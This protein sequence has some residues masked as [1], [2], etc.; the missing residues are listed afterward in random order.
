MNAKILEGISQEITGKT[1]G[2]YESYSKYP[3]TTLA[4]VLTFIEPSIGYFY[5]YNS[6]IGRMAPKLKWFFSFGNLLLFSLP[7][8]S[9]LFS[10]NPKLRKIGIA[11]VLF[12]RLFL[13]TIVVHF[14]MKEN[15]IYM[16]S[17]Y[18]YNF[19]ELD[20]IGK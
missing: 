5:L 7:S 11:G 2:E 17:G 4:Y 12:D 1:F 16:R 18:K 19:R 14:T 10:D 20:A 15:K 3:S 6:G 9:L 8:Y 13:G